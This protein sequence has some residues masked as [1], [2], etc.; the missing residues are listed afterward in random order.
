M[1]TRRQQVLIALREKILRRELR[2]GERLV[3]REQVQLIG[4]VQGVY[5]PAIAQICLAIPG[6]SGSG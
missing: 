2:P 5:L 4:Y 1:Q 3:E 6:A